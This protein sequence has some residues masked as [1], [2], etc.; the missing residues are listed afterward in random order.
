MVDGDGTDSVALEDKDYKELHDTRHGE[1]IRL[2]NYGFQ[3][4]RS[5]FTS[6]TVSE[7]GG[8]IYIAPIKQRTF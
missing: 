8:G 1:A 6:C 5:N 2:V 7:G 3:C 4:I